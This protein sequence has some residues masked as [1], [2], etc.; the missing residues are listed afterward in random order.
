MK[1]HDYPINFHIS[2][3]FSM[4]CLGDKYWLGVND[5]REKH[6]QRRAFWAI[7][8]RQRMPGGWNFSPLGKPKFGGISRVL[9]KNVL[10]S[11]YIYDDIEMLM[12]NMANKIRIKT[13]ISARMLLFKEQRQMVFE[14]QT[15]ALKRKKI[16]DFTSTDPILTFQKKRGFNEE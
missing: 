9:Q 14:Q 5:V 1:F 10:C 3:Y 16:I 7:E 4:I 15:C 8:G 6:G 12:L 11:L 13:L 2:H